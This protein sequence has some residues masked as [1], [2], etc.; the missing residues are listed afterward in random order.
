MQGGAALKLLVKEMRQT[1]DEAANYDALKPY[2]KKLK[3]QIELNQQVL[4]Y[5]LSFAMKGEHERYLSEA[6]LYMEFLGTIVVAW[7]WL[8]NATV[9]QKALITND[10]KG[11]STNFY[12]SKIHTMQFF[13]KYEV[14]HTASL[15]EILMDDMVLTIA[16]DNAILVEN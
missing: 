13:F 9:A 6:T 4:E 2:C 14:P 8:K 1:I 10:L 16:Q 3:E 5:L 7:L 11:Y 15:A 12:E